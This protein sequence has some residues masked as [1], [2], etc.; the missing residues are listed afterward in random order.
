[1]ALEQV[2]LRTP[3]DE[4]TNDVSVCHVGYDVDHDM[5]ELNKLAKPLVW[6]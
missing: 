6:G 2:G 4:G 1:M 3:I 5:K